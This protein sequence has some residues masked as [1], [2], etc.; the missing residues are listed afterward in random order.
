MG[1]V[2]TATV[3]TWPLLYLRQKFNVSLVM[4][5]GAVCFMF[6]AVMSYALEPGA[7]RH[8]MWLIYIVYGCGRA[9]WESTTKAVFADFFPDDPQ[10]AFANIVLQSGLASTV[11]FF[12]FPDLSPLQK[13]VILGVTAT[14]GAICFSIASFIHQGEQKAKEVEGGYMSVNDDN[15]V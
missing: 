6:V 2:G 1:A 10:A 5:I 13:E 12:V 15:Q 4:M 3:L 7:L 14:L 9:V 8:V 11:A